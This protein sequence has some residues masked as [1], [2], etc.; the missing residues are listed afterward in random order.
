[1]VNPGAKKFFP[2]G[3]LFDKGSSLVEALIA[4]PLLILLFSGILDLSS[5]YVASIYLSHL[6]HETLICL[7]ENSNSSL[8]L[9]KM[10]AKAQRI[11]WI[12]MTH[13]QPLFDGNTHHLL[14]SYRSG[15]KKYETKFSLHLQ[16]NSRTE[17]PM[18]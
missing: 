4:L 7:Q 8:C 13:L 6:G 11:S 9:S 12:K 1:M 15:T 16:K 3:A 18:Y 2:T 14:V 17:V 5:N 10:K